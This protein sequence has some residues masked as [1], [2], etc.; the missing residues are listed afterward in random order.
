MNDANA[1]EVLMVTGLTTAVVA[2]LVTAGMTM[3]IITGAVIGSVY[4][5]LK[6]LK[7]NEKE[8]PMIQTEKL[9]YT[10]K[11]QHKQPFPY[12][13]GKAFYYPALDFNQNLIKQLTTYVILNFSSLAIARCKQ[14]NS[15]R[16]E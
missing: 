3:A 1:I 12:F 9:I 15:K 16:T 5:L 13:Y 2:G 10:L 14:P 6:Q 8:Q 7:L 11:K 4:M